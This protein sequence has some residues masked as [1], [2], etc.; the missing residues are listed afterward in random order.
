MINKIGNITNVKW[1]YT[2]SKM[3]GSYG[4]QRV[5]FDSKQK[6]VEIR[7]GTIETTEVFKL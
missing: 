3:C 1:H 6:V 2:F 7:N 5:T 4:Y